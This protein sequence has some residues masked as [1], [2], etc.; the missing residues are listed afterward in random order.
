MRNVEQIAAIIRK[1]LAAEWHFFEITE[2]RVR[3]DL[4][5]FGWNGHRSRTSLRLSSF[6]ERDVG[7]DDI[8]SPPSG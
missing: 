8:D 1:R 6:V 7:F 5:E 2:V 4:D 3:E